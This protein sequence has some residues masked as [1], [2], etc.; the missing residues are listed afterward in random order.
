MDSARHE[1]EDGIP[2]ADII[3]ADIVHGNTD[4]VFCLLEHGEID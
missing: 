3:P 4:N 2:A 1:L